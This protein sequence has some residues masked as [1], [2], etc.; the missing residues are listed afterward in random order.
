MTL[1]MALNNSKMFEPYYELK[2]NGEKVSDK[3]KKYITEIEFDDSDVEAGLLRISVV[4]QDF[5]FSN[6]FDFNKGVK[7]ELL[8]G[9]INYN[10]T[11][12]KGEVTH[13]EASFGEDGV[14]S[15]VIGAMDKSVRMTANKKSRTWKN[16]KSSDVA[17]AIA[18]EYNFKGIIQDSQ[19]V[20][21]QITQ[22]NESDAQFL[23]K[24][25]DDEAF[26]LYVF[27]EKQTFYFGDRFGSIGVKDIL[28]Y[29]EKDCTIINFQPNLVDRKKKENVDKDGHKHRDKSGKT[30]KNKGAG[31][32]GAGG[33]SGAGDGDGSGDSGMSGSFEVEVDDGD[34]IGDGVGVIGHT[35]A[36]EG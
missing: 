17:Q 20:K 15:L 9:Y 8:M 27:P 16:C 30:G 12:F 13:F 26:E 21:E 36:M 6:R 4:D 28:H 14:R 25:A 35:G 31:K 23:K 3:Y 32:G 19:E 22:D 5:E 18:K 11:M 33:G 24:L 2:L 10:R 7:V 1:S 29:E 34:D